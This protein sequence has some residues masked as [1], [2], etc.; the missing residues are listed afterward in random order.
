MERQRSRRAV[1]APR[2]PRPDEAYERNERLDAARV[3]ADGAC[4]SG[5]ASG[6]PSDLGLGVDVDGLGVLGGTRATFGAA[7]LD[8]ILEA[9]DRTAEIR[10]DVAQLLGSE[11]QHDDHQYDQ[12]VPDAH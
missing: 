5:V 6:G 1:E 3:R 12:P 11:D 10:T 8:P 9:L 7:F 4:H 2:R